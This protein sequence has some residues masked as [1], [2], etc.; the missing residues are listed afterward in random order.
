M[1]MTNSLGITFSTA[2]ILSQDEFEKIVIMM[3]GMQEQIADL[4]DRVSALS[5]ANNDRIRSERTVPRAEP[6]KEPVKFAV[7]KPKDPS[8][9]STRF[10]ITAADVRNMHPE[11]TVKQ[12]AKGRYWVNVKDANSRMGRRTI[13]GDTKNEL[14]DKLL[15][16]YNGELPLRKY[17]KKADKQAPMTMSQKR[18]IA[19]MYDPSDFN[20]WRAFQEKMLLQSSFITFHEVYEYIRTKYG[21]VWE[22]ECK[23]RNYSKRQMLEMIYKDS[24]LKSVFESVLSTGASNSPFNPHALASELSKATKGQYSIRS[25]YHEMKVAD[26]IELPKGSNTVNMIK[27]DAKLKKSF[28]KAYNKLYKGH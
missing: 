7:D 28:M 11:S 17:V 15:K 18:R 6:V 27:S 20:Q 14:F 9:F 16:F 23:D 4:Q 2:V 10:S 8:R 26:N 5:T 21:I 24:M 1:D 19:S 12:N 25:I 13:A 3:N 22:Q